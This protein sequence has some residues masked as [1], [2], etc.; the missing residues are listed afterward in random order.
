MYSGVTSVEV[1]RSE[2][3]KRGVILP[4]KRYLKEIHNLRLAPLQVSRSPTIYIPKTHQSTLHIG[5]RKQKKKTPHPKFQLVVA[6][7]TLRKV[8]ASNRGVT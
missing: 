3:D 7:I 2:H 1:A 4:A 5:N 8:V 6:S